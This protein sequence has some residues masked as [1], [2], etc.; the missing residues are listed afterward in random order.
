MAKQAFTL[1][2]NAI[3]TNAVVTGNG[4][5]DLAISDE[6]P[7]TV[8]LRSLKLVTSYEDIL[9][10]SQDANGD[11][12]PISFG[13]DAV[14]EG[15]FGGKWFP[16]AYQFTSASRAERGPMRIVQLQPSIAGFDA[17]VD[18]IMYVGD[19][20]IARTSRQQGN[21]PDTKFRVRLR[22]TERDF[23]GPGAFQS[24][25]VSAMGEAFDV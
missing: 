3:L 24:V 16:I 7:N 8:A 4:T 22:V 21:L 10:P 12:Q 14:V 13:I 20:V 5:F 17:G 18:D 9:P 1:W 6:Q 25:K 23:G 2:D 19:E 11:T 15:E